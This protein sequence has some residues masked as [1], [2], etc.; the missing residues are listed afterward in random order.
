MSKNTSVA[1]GKHFESF[2]AAKIDEG[3][4]E[5]LS[6]AVREG[7]RLL[8]ERETRLDALRAALDE[9]DNSGVC[10]QT[11]WEIAQEAQQEIENGL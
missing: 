9:G 2:I 8:E 6:E 11:L 4:F 5:T 10:D 3:R 1:I 7:L